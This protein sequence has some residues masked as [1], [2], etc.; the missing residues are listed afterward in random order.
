MFE[1]CSSVIYS[2]FS[3]FPYNWFLLYTIKLAGI[4]IILQRKWFF[5]TLPSPKD[6]AQQTLWEIKPTLASNSLGF[7]LYSIKA[8]FPVNNSDLPID[9]SSSISVL[10]LFDFLDKQD[11]WSLFLKCC[12]LVFWNILLLSFCEFFL[13]RSFVG[14]FYSEMPTICPSLT[15]YCS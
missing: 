4:F 10:V 3:F 11:Y 15:K 6:K 9:K 12:L 2:I 14:L 1:S 13:Q 5:S 7:C 8:A